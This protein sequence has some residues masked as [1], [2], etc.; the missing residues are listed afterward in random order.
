VC[1]LSRGLTVIPL[2]DKNKARRE[3]DLIISSTCLL[4]TK[5]LPI[6]AQNTGDKMLSEINIMFAFKEFTM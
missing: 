3:V 5:Y 4:S 6:T 1:G 2:F